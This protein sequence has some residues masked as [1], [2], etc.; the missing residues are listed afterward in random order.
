MTINFNPLTACCISARSTIYLITS[1][2]KMTI[3]FCQSH[4]VFLRDHNLLAAIEENDHKFPS[5]NCVLYFCE[6]LDL[7]ADIEENDHKFPS[8]DC[9]LNFWEIHDLLAAI[10]ENGHRFTSDNCVLYFCE[11]LDL[12][13]D[14]EK[15][16][17]NFH[18]SIACCT[19]VRSMIYLPP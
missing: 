5:I 3:N 19:S 11:I 4:V 10:K 12:V 16:T 18:P 8:V 7:V 17:I 9:V 6:I 2:K 15:M 14:I 13:A 1:Y